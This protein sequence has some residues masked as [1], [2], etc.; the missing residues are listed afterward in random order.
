MD[1]APIKGLELFLILVGLLSGWFELFRVRDR[2]AVTV[3]QIL[4]VIFSRHR[5]PKTFVP[6]YAPEFCDE[7]LYSWLKRIGCHPYKN[8]TRNQ[9]ELHK[10]LCRG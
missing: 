4:R 2:K 8:K 10:E 6:D 9:M 7:T 5:M 1:Q 3:K